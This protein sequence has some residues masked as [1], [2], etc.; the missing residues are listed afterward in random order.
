ML[1][2]GRFGDVSDITGERI[3]S[4]VPGLVPVWSVPAMLIWLGFL[5][6]ADAV[7]FPIPFPFTCEALLDGGSGT[8]A[9]W[10]YGGGVSSRSGGGISVPSVNEP[11]PPT[12]KA[13][14]SNFDVGLEGGFLERP[15]EG[16]RFL[17]DMMAVVRAPYWRWPELWFGVV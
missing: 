13:G 10:I 7:L 5:P 16:V 3:P 2:G 4:G 6:V 14:S 11:K 1:D 9:G 17:V 15:E 12:E 8:F